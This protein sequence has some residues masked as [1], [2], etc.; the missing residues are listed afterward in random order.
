MFSSGVQET[1]RLVSTLFPFCTRS[2]TLRLLDS[3]RFGR[4]YKG[5]SDPLFLRLS[6]D[7]DGLFIESFRHTNPLLKPHICPSMSFCKGV[8]MSLPNPMPDPQ[9][10]NDPMYQ[11]IDTQPESTYPNN[12]DSSLSH[13]TTRQ[14]VPTSITNTFPIVVTIPSNGFYNG[15]AIRATKFITMSFANA[16]GMEQLNNR[17]FF[18]QQLNGDDFQ[19]YGNDGL[20]VDGRNY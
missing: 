13:I 6:T 9:N 2:Q 4:C 7:S 3:R 15:Y 16:T 14:Y 10:P 8:C 17:Q 19:L 11:F 18:V 20:P 12:P 1:L 5:R